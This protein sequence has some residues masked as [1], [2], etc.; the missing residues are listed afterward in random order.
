MDVVALAQSLAAI[1]R[2]V[3]VEGPPTGVRCDKAVA[4]QASHPWGSVLG[5]GAVLGILLNGL[6][7][8]DAAVLGHAIAQG[9]VP[10]HVVGHGHFPY[11]VVAA[12]EILRLVIEEAQRARVLVVEHEEVVVLDAAAAT[13][14]QHQLPVVFAGDV[15]AEAV[16]QVGQLVA[17]KPRQ[18]HQ[19][20]AR[21]SL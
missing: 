6:L 13:A 17:L 2:E 21:A 8:L 15:V 11:V 3:H 10:G 14:V 18:V 9:R 16:W 12:L 20:V 19:R 7:V 5:D 1:Q 4:A